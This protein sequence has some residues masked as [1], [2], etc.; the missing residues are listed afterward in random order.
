MLKTHYRQPIDWT[1]RGIEESQKTLD[2][3]Y[4]FAPQ[5][6]E[7]ALHESALEALSDDLNTPRMIAEL[8]GLDGRGAHAE[9]IS[10]LRAS[11]S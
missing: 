8:H 11:A 9:L 10:T 2:R 3:W 5:G 7:G 6:G 1:L 4:D